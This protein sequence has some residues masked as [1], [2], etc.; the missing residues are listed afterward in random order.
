MKKLMI[1]AY[2]VV[3]GLLLEPPA[4]IASS[5]EHSPLLMGNTEDGSLVY[6]DATNLM[7][8][9]NSQGVTMFEYKL[10]DKKG[11]ETN[12][13]A[14][15]HDCFRNGIFNG[16]PRWWSIKKGSKLIDI[17]ATSA[18]S[19][20]MLVSVCG[21]ANAIF[22]TE[23]LMSDPGWWNDEYKIRYGNIEK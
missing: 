9:V 17:K 11:V 1:V 16:K 3:A 14:I 23:N 15:T 7:I 6:V 2:T 12:R 18:G 4:S 13:K 10:I 20:N 22:Q 19:I 5:A 8:H 21:T